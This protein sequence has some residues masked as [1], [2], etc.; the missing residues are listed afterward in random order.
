MSHSDIIIITGTLFFSATVGVYALIR[1]INKH[2][3]P[4]VNTLE[5]QG[6]I[7]LDYIEPTRAH[8]IY[9]DLVEQQFPIH[10]RISDHVYHGSVHSY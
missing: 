1:V 2:T 10:E 5:R 9:P 3:R 7:Q 8:D 4:P 6:D